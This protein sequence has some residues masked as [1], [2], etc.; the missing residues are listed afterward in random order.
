MRARRLSSLLVLGPSGSGKSSLVRA[1]LVP[2]LKANKEKWLVIDAFRPRGNPALELG[3]AFGKTRENLGLSN[4]E[5]RI[6]AAFRRG[7]DAVSELLEHAEDLRREIGFRDAKIVLVV[8]QAEELFTLG[9]PDVDVFLATLRALIMAPASPFIVIWTMRSDFLDRFQKNPELRKFESSDLRVGPMSPDDVAQVIRGPAE[10]AGIELET[11]LV[12]KM[13]RDADT[14]DALPLLAFNLRE[15]YDRYGDDGHITI[16]EYDNLDGLT[17]SLAKVAEEVYRAASLREPGEKAVRSAFLAQARVN[18][19]GEIARRTAVRDELP[20]EALPV[21]EEYV[22][23]RLLVAGIE[24]EDEEQREVLEVAHEALF[25]SWK[26]LRKWLRED[27]EFL[28]WQ[29]R[30]TLIATEWDE[31]KRNKREL[32]TARMHSIETNMKRHP[33]YKPTGLEG[34]FIKA[35][36]RRHMWRKL[37]RAGLT[38]TLVISGIIAWGWWLFLQWEV[39]SRKVAGQALHLAEAPGAGSIAHS[40]LLANL[41]YQ[42]SEQVENQSALLTILQQTHSSGGFLRAIHWEHDAPVTSLAMSPGRN[43]PGQR[44]KRRPGPSVLDPTR[45]NAD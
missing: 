27:H 7:E 25:R 42:E 30:L 10:L 41:A 12:Q 33:H 14:D 31:S 11:G 40:L 45:R 37:R 3:M 44:R 17:G 18:E 20:P 13:I 19:K 16:E 34:D 21:M 39:H 36:K 5:R 22:K 2:R 32:T 28:L 23:A 35:C 9:G 8:D 6:E 26:R 29:R 15:L 1:G 43:L 38:L 4:N 24:G